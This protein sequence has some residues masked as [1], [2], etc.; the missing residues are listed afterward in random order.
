MKDIIINIHKINSLAQ[1][2]KKINRNIFEFYADKDYEIINKKNNIIHSGF[3]LKSVPHIVI[4]SN[5]YIKYNLI[6]Y[7]YQS[8]ES[9]LCIN[10]YCYA[11]NNSDKHFASRYKILPKSSCIF[12]VTIVQSQ[13]EEN[14]NFN[15]INY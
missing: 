10:A 14:Y 3:F 15:I 6:P 5:I 1:N 12:Y 9:N 11:E 7:P 8:I 4:P 2:P 13:Y